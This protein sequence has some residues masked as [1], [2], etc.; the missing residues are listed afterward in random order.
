MVWTRQSAENFKHTHKG[1]TEAIVEENIF[2]RGSK[3]HRTVPADE[4]GLNPQDW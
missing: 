2:D 4:I 1:S 3:T